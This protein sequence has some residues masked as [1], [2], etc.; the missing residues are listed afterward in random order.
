MEKSDAPGVEIDN[1]IRSAIAR[2]VEPTDE[3]RG[4]ATV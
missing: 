1:I 2:R 4:D 3:W